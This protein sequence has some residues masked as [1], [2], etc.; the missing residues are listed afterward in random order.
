[1]YYKVEARRWFQSSYGNTYH[2]CRVSKCEG[3]GTDWKETEIGTVQFNYG[4]GD[5]WKQTAFSI[6]DKAE[7]LPDNIKS[8]A[9]FTRWANSDKFA[10]FVKD[11]KRK[12][13][14][15]FN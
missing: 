7:E 3:E 15:Y 11:V 1:M 4:Y 12:R 14:L 13:D 9:D 6:M 2:S 5:H 8:Y 10:F